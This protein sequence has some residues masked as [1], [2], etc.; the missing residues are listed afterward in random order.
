[1]HLFLAVAQ[2]APQDFCYMNRAHKSSAAR[3]GVKHCPH[4]PVERTHAGK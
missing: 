3:L 1:M 4:F 2:F